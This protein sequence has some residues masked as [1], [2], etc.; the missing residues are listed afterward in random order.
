M[1]MM[2]CLTPFLRKPVAPQPTFLLTLHPILI[3]SVF[4]SRKFPVSLIV[5][6]SGFFSI[7]S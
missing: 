4:V 5:V 6:V 3:L 7:H 2:A 1:Y